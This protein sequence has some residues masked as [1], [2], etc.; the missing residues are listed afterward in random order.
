[1]VA[2][3]VRSLAQRSATAAREIKTLIQ[4]SEA[5]VKSGAE[6]VMYTGRSTSEIVGSIRQV[7]DTIGVINASMSEQSTGI[8]QINRAVAEMEQSTQQNAALVE[9]ATAASSVLNEQ[10][11]RL[12]ATIGA[13]KL[14]DRQATAAALAVDS[15]KRVR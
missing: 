1:V 11:R 9:Q 2:S 15:V 5:S 12:V 6:R 13:F 3:E 14:D 8:S 4:R 10:V 7:T